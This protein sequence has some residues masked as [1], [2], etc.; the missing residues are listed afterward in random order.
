MKHHLVNGWIAGCLTFLCLLVV[1]TPALAA[2]E[3]G[4]VT[5][6]D[7]NVYTTVKI[8]DTWWMTEN[9]RTKH[10]Q[11]GDSISIYPE[12]YL[13]TSGQPVTGGSKYDYCVHYTYPNRNADNV[14]VYGLNYTWSAVF[15]TRNI[16]PVGWTV[17]DS[18]DWMNLAKAIGVGQYINGGFSDVGRYLKATTGWAFDATSKP[19]TDS[20]G[21]NAVPSGDFNSNGYSLFGQQA[22]FW[23]KHEV[24]PGL[25][26]RYYVYLK[27]DGD[28]L[29][30]G[31]YRNNNTISVRC[32]KSAVTN[33][34]NKPLVS[35]LTL[36]PNPVVDCLTVSLA[37][38]SLKRV[39]VLDL[40]GKA[41]LDGGNQ[42]TVDV[43]RLSAGVYLVRVAT[44]NG[45]STQ[46]ILKR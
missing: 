14:A 41:V 38:G 33:A 27:H 34:V 1:T 37:D 16:C 29:M 8:G 13:N 43:S 31:S 39:T 6:A 46:R 45:V 26:G 19:V 17:P 23:T 9:L 7:G 40:A 5:D 18:A 4:T 11:N 25:A 32:I 36:S 35:E 28:E 22:R 2:L 42:S 10:F 21:F 20:L 44:S 3:T 15:D 30:L 12:T 24:D